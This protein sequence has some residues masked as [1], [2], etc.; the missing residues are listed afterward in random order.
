MLFKEEAGQYTPP[1]LTTA[2]TPQLNFETSKAR[3]GCMDDIYTAVTNN[4]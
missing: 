2:N 1:S 3:C 4:G